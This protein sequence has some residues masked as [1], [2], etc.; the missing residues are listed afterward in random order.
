MIRAALSALAFTMA[1]SGALA[2]P[3]AP[4]A[5]PVSEAE[6]LAQIEADTAGIKHKIE[7]LRLKIA[8]IAATT[9]R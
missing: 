5:P 2:D 4:S 8:M 7:L 9:P 6:L 3:E 1:A